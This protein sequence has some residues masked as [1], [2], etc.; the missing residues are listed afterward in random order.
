MKNQKN[1]IILALILVAM[2][3]F[4]VSNMGQKNTTTQTN[5]VDD[6]TVAQ[7]QIIDGKQIIEVTARGGYNP[8][9]IT[10][11]AG[12]P[13]ILRMKTSGTFD[14]SSA[15]VIPS[16]GVQKMLPA[17]GVTDFEIPAQTSGSTIHGTCGMGMYRLQINFQ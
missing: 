2:M 7:L 16:L 8:R 17:T 11:K 1:T 4:F 6:T 10:A 13:T 5:K 14:C 15:F 12:V 3:I 9:E